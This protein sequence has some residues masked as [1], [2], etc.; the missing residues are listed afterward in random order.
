MCGRHGL[1]AIPLGLAI[2]ARQ[3][4]LLWAVMVGGSLLHERRRDLAQNWRP[5]VKSATPLI[6]VGALFVAFVIHNGGVALSASEEQKAGIH[7]GN[8]FLGLAGVAL[9]NL[10]VALASWRRI[11]PGPQNWR[12]WAGGVLILAVWMLLFR[13][14]H[15]WNAV[16]NGYFLRNVLLHTVQ[17]SSLAKAAAVVCVLWGLFMLWMTPLRRQ[18]LW[19]IY[20]ASLLTLM[21]SEL[22][23]PRYIL[24]PWAL[25][26]LA[27][28]LGST[29]VEAINLCWQVLLGGALVVTILRTPYFP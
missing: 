7:V 24:V 22:V 27:R 25:F 17:L 28:P 26:L 18:E 12:L 2:L 13:V 19:V 3:T 8:V 4:H 16:T 5:V 1:A 9:L 20:P 11:I 23:E 29:R 10:P 14:S 6:M 21:P 15:P